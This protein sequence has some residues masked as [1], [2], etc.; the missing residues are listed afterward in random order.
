[1]ARRS[2]LRSL[3]AHTALLRA[4]VV[5]LAGASLTSFA[6]AWAWGVSARADASGA[7]PNGAPPSPS[8]TVLPLFTIAKSENKNQVQYTVRVD[9]HCAPAGPSPV[10]AYW[11]MLEHG[12]NAT[13]PILPIEVQA[14]GLASQTVV[15]TTKDGGEVHATLRALPSRV[16]RVTTSRASDGACRATAEVAIGGQPAHL[17]NVYAHLAWLGVDYLLLQGWTLDGTHVV[18]EKIPR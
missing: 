2:L 7:P 13:E 12:V 15:A 1:M 10:A 4:R 11:R 18:R 5:V 6:G 3:W 16:V 8:G 9:G 14:Y 17:F